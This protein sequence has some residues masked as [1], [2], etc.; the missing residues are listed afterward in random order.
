M[1]EGRFYASVLLRIFCFCVILRSYPET[2]SFLRERVGGVCLPSRAREGFSM[3]E[4]TRVAVLSVIVESADN[5]GTVEE[6]NALLHENRAFILG[7]MGI[8]YRERGISLISV[9]MDAPP[10]VIST[11]AGRLGALPGV[12]VKTAMASE[13]ESGSRAK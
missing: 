10:D 7:R 9:A 6:I 8:P 2:K 3:R 11:L 4:G 1:E 12:R 13:K 5:G